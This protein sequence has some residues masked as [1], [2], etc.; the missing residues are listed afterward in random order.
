MLYIGAVEG[1]ERYLGPVHVY[2]MTEEQS[3]VSGNDD[4]LHYASAVLKHQY[5]FQGTRWYADNTREPI[6]DETLREG[7]VAIG[8]VLARNDLPTTSG[9]PRY[10]LKLDFAALFD[11][12]LDNDALETA[13]RLGRFKT[14]I[15]P[16]ALLPAYRSFALVPPPVQA[17]YSSPF[18]MARRASLHPALV[19]SLRRP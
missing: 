14:R 16:R 12:A 15:C 9:R 6:R 18:P 2:R 19:Q 1:H 7:L 17:V 5:D 4:R 13:I 11:P 8:A 10:A 3:Q